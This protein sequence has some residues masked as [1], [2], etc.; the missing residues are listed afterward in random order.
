MLVTDVGDGDGDKFEPFMADFSVI[1]LTTTS[2]KNFDSVAEN[3][4]HYV[5]NNRVLGHIDKP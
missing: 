1:N 5:T 4:H 2:R 3:C